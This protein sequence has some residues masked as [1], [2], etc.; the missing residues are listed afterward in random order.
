M[1]EKTTRQIEEMKKQTIGVEVEM[2]NITREK[3]AR[4]KMT[5]RIQKRQ[6][7]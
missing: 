2:N 7:N 3:A 1:S 6:G 4:C 5:S